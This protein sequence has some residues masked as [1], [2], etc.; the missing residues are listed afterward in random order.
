MQITQQPT[1]NYFLE[2]RFG[3]FQIP[4]GNANSQIVLTP[5]VGSVAFLMFVVRNT[6]NVTQSLGYQYQPITNFQL[7]GSSS[8]NIVGG[9]PITSALALQVLNQYWIESSFTSETS[10]GLTDNKANVYIWSFGADP[11]SSMKSANQYSARSF[12]GNEQ[13][14]ITWGS[15]LANPV[16][17]DVYAMCNSVIDQGAGY[18]KKMS[19]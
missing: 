3:L 9:Q 19:L 2:S 12:F 15:T 8:E 4:A 17:V 13:L 6:T 10:L 18:I 1:H 11:I 5:I 14:Q 16:Q 7:L